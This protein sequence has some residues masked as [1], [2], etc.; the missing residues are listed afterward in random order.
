MHQFS[1]NTVT[2]W[3][4]IEA[5]QNLFWEQLLDDAGGRTAINKNR[6]ETLTNGRDYT[7]SVISQF[8]SLSGR[9]PGSL[10]DQLNRVRKS[11]NA[12]TH[13][14]SD[15]G[16]EGAGDA[17]SLANLMLSKLLGLEVA[18]PIALI[19]TGPNPALHPY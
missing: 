4:V 9:Y 13:D 7:A 5:V 14:L 16:A 1:S 18:F 10:F 11:R 6:R 12:I 15:P 17:I 2:A 19:R 8:L 3:L